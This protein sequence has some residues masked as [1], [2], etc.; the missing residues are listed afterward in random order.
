LKALACPIHRGG[1]PRRSGTHD[2][3]VEFLVVGLE[4]YPKFPAKV[5]NRGVDQSA[6]SEKY[7]RRVSRSQPKSGHDLCGGLVFRPLPSVN[8]PV[9]P[10]ECANRDRFR[11]VGTANQ[12][13]T[14]LLGFKENLPATNKGSQNLSAEILL[15]ANDFPEPFRADTENLRLPI[16]KSS[17]R[18]GAAA[19]QVN[20]TR[21]LA[22][23]VIG[24]LRRAALGIPDTCSSLQDD[25]EAEI[26]V[27]GIPKSL[28][29]PQIALLAITAE[30]LDFRV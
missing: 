27:S 11:I 25:E 3:E 15:D 2:H 22:R 5:L 12:E 6:V 4:P 20:V 23:T 9:S 29:I 8:N 17:D 28:S 1:K 7:E 14:M 30:D 18:C 10:E 26:N 24:D 16:R 19:H 21:K 13:D